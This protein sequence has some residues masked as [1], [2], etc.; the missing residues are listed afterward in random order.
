MRGAAS[1]PRAPAIRDALES[2][3]EDWGKLQSLFATARL[4]GASLAGAYG[5]QALL[6]VCVAGVSVVLV[7]RRPGAGAE[8]AILAA[9][10]MLCTPH[11][12]DYDLAVTGVPLA[13]L[14]SREGWLPYEKAGGGGGFFV[15]ACGADGDGGLGAAGGAAFAGGGFLGWFVGG[16]GGRRL[17]GPSPVPPDPPVG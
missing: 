9:A 12:L 3:R 4:C 1:L 10:A 16:R 8:V 11:L 14:A 5:A 7:R 6:G 15:A 2:H 13:W 17:G